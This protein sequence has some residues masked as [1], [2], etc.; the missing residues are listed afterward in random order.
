LKNSEVPDSSR[1]LKYYLKPSAANNFSIAG[2]VIVTGVG[3]P[4]LNLWGSVPSRL[5]N[6][7]FQA[8]QCANVDQSTVGPGT[9]RLC[10]ECREDQGE[11]LPPRQDQGPARHSKH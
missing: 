8:R 10:S 3:T 11:K 7:A 9:N 5:R 4:S 6:G 1:G 2:M